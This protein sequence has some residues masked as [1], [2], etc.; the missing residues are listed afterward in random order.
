MV[1]GSELVIG[2]VNTASAQR[3]PEMWSRDS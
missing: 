1:T 3:R 2:A